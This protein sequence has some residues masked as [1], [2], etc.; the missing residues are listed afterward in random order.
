MSLRI[1]GVVLCGGKSSRMGLPKATLPFGD[2]LMLQRVVRLLG[3]VVSPIVVVSADK[4]TLPE[5]P[6]DVIVAHD[7]REGRGPLEGLFAGLL[8]AREHVDAVYAT[9]CDVPLLATGFVKKMIEELTNFDVAVPIDGKFHHPLAAVY[10]TT[11]VPAIEELITN[12]RMRPVFLFDAVNT[13]RVRVEQLKQADPSLHTL[14]NL[15]QPADYQ[16][17]IELA[18]FE[19]PDDVLRLLIANRK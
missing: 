11:V 19:L 4:Q 9:S 16:R 3:E 17:A 1:G 2:E 14:M 6:D 10:R 15:N 7:R 13:N 12:D 5:L 8:A 18:G